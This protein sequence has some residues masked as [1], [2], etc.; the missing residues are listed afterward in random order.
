[1]V[2]KYRLKFS[3]MDAAYGNAFANERRFIGCNE[4]ALAVWARATKLA[5]T[6]G[7]QTP[8]ADIS[9]EAMRI[10][11]ASLTQTYKDK[12]AQGRDLNADDIET[13]LKGRAENFKTADPALDV[14]AKG[15]KNT[16]QQGTGMFIFD[17]G[18]LEQE[19]L[20]TLFHV[21]MAEHAYEHP[22]KVHST[23]P[24]NVDNTMAARHLQKEHMA[25]YWVFAPEVVANTQG[26]TKTETPKT[27]VEKPTTGTAHSAQRYR[28]ALGSGLA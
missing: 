10:L 13:F 22:D 26:A 2:T 24:S 27:T 3:D 17:N 15:G 18:I 25:D 21:M 20:H 23:P 14:I 9:D 11:N 7:R 12:I 6:E 28:R 16:S 19:E 1:M 5:A 4:F 8:H